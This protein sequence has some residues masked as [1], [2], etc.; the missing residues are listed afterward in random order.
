MLVPG[1]R[2]EGCVMVIG[3]GVIVA[4]VVVVAIVVSRRR[5]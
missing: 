3:L 4:A 1:P 2:R 5:D